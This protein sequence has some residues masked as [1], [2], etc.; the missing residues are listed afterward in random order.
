[1]FSNRKVTY[2]F[3]LVSFASPNPTILGCYSI[4]IGPFQ[5]MKQHL[6]VRT[7]KKQEFAIRKG[8]HKQRIIVEGAV[9]ADLKIDFYSIKK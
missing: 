5:G 2:Q 4:K 8:S 9:V 1:M 6:F 3:V 7:T